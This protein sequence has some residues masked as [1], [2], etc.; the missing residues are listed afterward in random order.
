[1]AEETDKEGRLFHA[2][3]LVAAI[4]GD[5][6]AAEAQAL[7]ALYSLHES[8]LYSDLNRIAAEL[9]KVLTSVPIEGEL[10]RIAQSELPDAQQRLQQVL[11]LTESAANTSLNAVEKA[12]PVSSIPARPSATA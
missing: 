9:N 4:E 10:S 2:H 8:A 6:D 5:D 7:A 3:Q 12:L 1:M 11:D